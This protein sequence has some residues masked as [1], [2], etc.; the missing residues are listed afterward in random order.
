MAINATIAV[1]GPSTRNRRIDDMKVF[2]TQLLH[3][4]REQLP[5]SARKVPDLQRRRVRST[6][7]GQCVGTDTAGALGIPY[8]FLIGSLAKET[9]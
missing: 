4:H 8:A 2:E 7:T 3:A 6:G 1:C 9:S 5:R